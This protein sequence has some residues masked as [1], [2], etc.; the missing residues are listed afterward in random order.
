MAEKSWDLS[1]NLVEFGWREALISS[2][3][4]DNDIKQATTKY[5]D[6]SLRSG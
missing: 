4:T 3:K 2:F 6:P 1:K 5:R